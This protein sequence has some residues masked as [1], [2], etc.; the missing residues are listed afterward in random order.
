MGHA[1]KYLPTQSGIHPMEFNQRFPFISLAMQ[2][3]HFVQAG[4]DLNIL[5]SPHC[6]ASYSNKQILTNTIEFINTPKLDDWKSSIHNN[7]D[8]LLYTNT[9]RVNFLP[10]RNTWPSSQAL[11]RLTFVKTFCLLFIFIARHFRKWRRHK[12]WLTR[13]AATCWPSDFSRCAE[14]H[15]DLRL[16]LLKPEC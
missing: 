11:A 2:T 3:I 5:C 1:L 15:F 10:A 16:N 8:R 6:K 7:A 12:K 4:I 14:G 13:N 9:T